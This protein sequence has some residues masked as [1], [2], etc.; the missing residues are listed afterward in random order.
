MATV[1]YTG[2][3]R[4]TGHGGFTFYRDEARPLP[5]DVAAGLVGHPMFTVEGMQEQPKRRQAVKHDAE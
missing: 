2:P 1:T 3:D 5:D 4:M